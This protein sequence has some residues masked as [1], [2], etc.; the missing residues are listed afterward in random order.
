MPNIVASKVWQGGYSRC[1]C[2]N[3]S[4]SSTGQDGVNNNSDTLPRELIAKP[5]AVIE[6][7]KRT[8]NI[9]KLKED[10]ALSGPSRPSAKMS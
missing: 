2:F 7:V 1:S 8:G 6:P 5:G 9:K 4:I 3:L 10:P